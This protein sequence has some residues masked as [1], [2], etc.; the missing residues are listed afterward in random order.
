MDFQISFFP[1]FFTLIGILLIFIGFKGY[2]YDIR[3][4]ALFLLI[5]LLSLILLQII[6]VTYYINRFKINEIEQKLEI[7]QPRITEFPGFRRK[8]KDE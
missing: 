1:V 4:L 2:L 7:N 8:L 3:I 5:I 6:R